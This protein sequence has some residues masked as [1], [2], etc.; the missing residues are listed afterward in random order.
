MKKK[1]LL[2]L[3]VIVIAGGSAF[4][5][6]AATF[7]SPI[8]PGDWLI[9]PTIG[10][11]SYGGWGFA[12]GI[13]GAVEYALPIPL[14]VGGEVGAAFGFGY[15]WN[16]MAIPILG[17]VAWHPNFEVPNLDVY[18]TLKLGAD[19]GIL[20][21]D[22]NDGK[23]VGAG[24]AFG[25]NTGARYFFTPKIGVFGELGWE[26]YTFRTKYSGAWGSAKAKWWIGT[27]FHTGITFKI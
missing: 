3:L 27:F 4:A 6:D 12:L 15:F 19:I 20:L 7:P 25:F 22:Y 2:V 1:F 13:T 11:G 5:F 24:F 17:K 8:K 23:K 21:D 16:S 14:T 26:D 18:V 9:S 10:L